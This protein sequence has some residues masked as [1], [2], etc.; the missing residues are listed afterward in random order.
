V[1]DIFNLAVPLPNRK[2]DHNNWG[3]FNSDNIGA[4]YGWPDGDYAER[5][6]IYQD[7]INYQQGLFWFLANDSRLPDIVRRIS[8]SWGLAADEFREHGNWPPQL[9]IREA[10]RMVSDYVVTEHNALAA[11]EVEDPVGMASYTIDAHNCKRVVRAGRAVNEG[12]VEMTPLAPFSIPYRAIRPRRREC[13]NL[14][15]PVCVSASHSAFGSIRM[16]PVLM[17]LGQSAGIAAVLAIEEEAA[18]VQDVSYSS[19][20][21]KLVQEGQVLSEPKKFPHELEIIGKHYLEEPVPFPSSAIHSIRK[22]RERKG[23]NQ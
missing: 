17:I 21:K 3:G 11:F 14:L 19:L 22:P 16:E 6:R 9:Y 20:R 5:E 15:V 18:I 10:R 13:T 8:S 4:N 2:F 7:H 12:N 1:F 23:A